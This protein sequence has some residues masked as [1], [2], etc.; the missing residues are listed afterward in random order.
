MFRSHRDHHLAVPIHEY[1]FVVS[2]VC[3]IMLYIYN[4]Q[5]E[6]HYE[7]KIHV[8]YKIMRILMPLHQLFIKD[9]KIMMHMLKVTL[10]FC[11]ELR[12]EGLKRFACNHL[13]YTSDLQHKQS[14]TQFVWITQTNYMTELCKGNGWIT[15]FDLGRRKVWF[16]TWHM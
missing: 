12:K 5:Q 16:L 13:N 1:I 15:G 2:T 10:W 11:T 14:C 3:L 8:F 9:L 4:T 7:D 6:A